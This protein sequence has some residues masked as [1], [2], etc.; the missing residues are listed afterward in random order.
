M[1]EIIIT[2]RLQVNISQ[3]VRI[4]AAL[5]QNGSFEA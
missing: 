2:G 3:D 1:L 5:D 4:I